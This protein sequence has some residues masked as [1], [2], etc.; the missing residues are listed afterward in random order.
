MT[1]NIESLIGKRVQI[2]VDCESRITSFTR[3]YIVIS[4]NLLRHRCRSHSRVYIET[5]TRPR[6]L[7]VLISDEN[8]SAAIRVKQARH[9]A[10]RTKGVDESARQIEPGL[11]KTQPRPQNAS[12]AGRVAQRQEDIRGW[13]SRELPALPVHRKNAARAEKKGIPEP[14]QKFRGDSVAATRCRVHGDS[15]LPWLWRG[16]EEDYTMKYISPLSFAC[17][18]VGAP[19]LNISPPPRTGKVPQITVPYK[20]RGGRRDLPRRADPLNL[21]LSA[22]IFSPC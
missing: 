3:A 8:P 10:S 14:V 12:P 20:K 2:F 5:S 11:C 4:G 13:R 1:N 18:H 17:E 16:R 19:L 21:L 15:L 6:Y 9:D 7:Q 22:S